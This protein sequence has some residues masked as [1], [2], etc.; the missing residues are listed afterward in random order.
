MRLTD[1]SDERDQDWV[2]QAPGIRPRLARGLFLRIRGAAMNAR[3]KARV[4]HRTCGERC[5]GAHR[6]A[7]DERGQNWV[8]QTSDQTGTRIA[9]C[10]GAVAG[11]A[12][13][14]KAPAIA[15]LAAAG[16][17]VRKGDDAPVLQGSDGG[18]P[19]RDQ[20]ERRVPPG[21]IGGRWSG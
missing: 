16:G 6:I 3:F 17:Y 11:A 18:H 7:G 5:G 20:R 4:E 8:R 1:A 21:N 12:C 10:M 9:R 2:R 19:G 13:V 15:A 14:R